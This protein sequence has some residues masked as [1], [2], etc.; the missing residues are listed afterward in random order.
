MPEN[1][2][3]R[4]LLFG[5]NP[6]DGNLTRLRQVPLSDDGRLKKKVVKLIHT[7]RKTA[8]KEDKQVNNQLVYLLIWKLRFF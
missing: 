7:K 6:R 5:H 1:K 3:K 4:Y 8:E 2:T